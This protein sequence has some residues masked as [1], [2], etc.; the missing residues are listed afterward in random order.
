M[1]F[2][3]FSPTLKCQYLLELVNNLFQRERE[4]EGERER[5]REKEEK[6]HLQTAERER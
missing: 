5:E 6:L 2:L 1:A 3:S 4:R